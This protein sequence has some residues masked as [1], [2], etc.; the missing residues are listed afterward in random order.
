MRAIAPVEYVVIAF[1]GNQ[2]NG[3]IAP[4][5]ARLVQSGTV[6]ILD[7]VFVK[8]DAAGNI[9]WFEY[10]ELDEGVP[11][12]EI[13][14]E[15]DGL[16]GDA[17]VL[18]A[19][20]VLDADSSALVILWEDLWAAELGQAIRDSGGVLVAG[21][22]LSHDEVQAAIAAFDNDGGAS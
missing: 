18:A 20:E 7:L 19:A 5:I 22:R 11:F 14:G 3:E 9:T 13:D 6:R 12:A 10:D 1:P 21:E 8:K 15:A 17:D 16:F 2:F 4:A